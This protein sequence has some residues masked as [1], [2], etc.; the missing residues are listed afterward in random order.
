MVRGSERIFKPVKVEF[1]QVHIA[2]GFTTTP[3]A[4]KSKTIEGSGG[5]QHIFVKMEKKIRAGC[6]RASVDLIV[7]E[8]VRHFHDRRWWIRY[9][10]A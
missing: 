9:V 6:G 1:G 4:V 10:I 5:K 7:V 8:E 3:A 2:G